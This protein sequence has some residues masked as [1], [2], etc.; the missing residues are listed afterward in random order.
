MQV[1]NIPLSDI[2]PSPLNPR[3]TFDA[4]EL[5]ELANSIKE[6][7]LIQPITIRKTPKGAEHKYEIVCG[8]RRYRACLINEMETIEAVVKELDDQQAFL[9]MVLE[10]LQRREVD[11]LEEGAAIKHLYKEGG[12]KV[13]QIAKA[14]GKSTSYV[15]DRIRLTNISDKFAA[16]LR[17]R[18]LWLIHLQEIAK[19]DKAQQEILY[20]ACFTPE[21][22]SR[23]PQKILKMEDLAAMIDEHVMNAIE[24]A[25]FYPSDATFSACGAC[26]GCKFNTA[27]SPGKFGADNKPRCMKRELFLAKNMESVMRQAKKCGLPIVYVGTKEENASILEACAHYEIEPLALGNREYVL[28]PKEPN[29]EAFTD[30]EY[31]AKR[32]ANYQSKKAL[33]DDNLKDGTIIAVYEV[34]F[35]GNLSGVQKFLYNTPTD[36]S[37]NMSAQSAYKVRSIDNLKRSLYESQEREQND[38]IE[39]LRTL[40]HDSTYSANGSDLVNREEAILLAVLLK[41]MGY[42][43]KKSIGLDFTASL[44]METVLSIALQHKNEIFREYLKNTLSEESVCYAAD[45]AKLLSALVDTVMPEQNSEMVKCI[46]EKYDKKRT[47]IK[48]NIEAIR[49]E[50]MQA[51]QAASKE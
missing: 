7:G 38:I 30:K 39:G 3:K 14:L 41:R 6:N 26:E 46:S 28:V 15:C 5:L 43:F 11:P 20:N 48:A 36:E 49:V 17:E 8:E 32:L 12:Y 16:L 19:L 13:A 47:D 2:S 22:I 44:D 35:N 31:Y 25:R 50:M 9:C 45:L 23:W 1:R 40:L 10:N 42:Q 37:G 33:F 4:E 18:V 27:T 21:H 29:E 24:T 34:S 51:E